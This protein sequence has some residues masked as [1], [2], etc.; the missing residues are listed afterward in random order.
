MSFA[1][2][3]LVDALDLTTLQ[4]GL[5]LC[6]WSATSAVSALVTRRVAVRVDGT[7]AL[8]VGMVGAGVGLLLLTALAPGDGV[9]RLVPGLVVAGLASGV[10][11]AGLARQATATLPPERA[12]LG[13]GV[14]N[15]AR[16]VGA[17]IGISLVTV[18]AHADGAG[19][20]DQVAGWNVVTVLAAVISV[21]GALAAVGVA[22]R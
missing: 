7:V 3:F 22:R 1:C 4:A 8:A 15:T 5:V 18:I 20:A 16:Y 19:V 14:N 10:V 6:L 12:A 2:T 13:V 21:A 17:S 9:A 11:N